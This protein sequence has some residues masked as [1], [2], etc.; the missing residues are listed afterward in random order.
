MIAG[1]WAHIGAPLRPGMAD[2]EG[3]RKVVG[4]PGGTPRRVLILGVTPELWRLGWPVGSE[5]RA[6]DL[7][8]EMIGALW[9]GPSGTAVEGDWRALPFPPESFDCVLCDGGLVLLDYPE[10]Q[11]RLAAAVAGVLRPGGRFTIRLFCKPEGDSVEAIRADLAARLI[12]SVHVLKLRLGMALQATPEEG[13]V[14]ND[15]FER[16]GREF[17]GLEG[18]QAATGWPREEVLT[19]SSYEGTVNRY[20]FLSDV[21]SVRVLESGGHL[22][23]DERLESDYPLGERCPLYAFRKSSAVCRIPEVVVR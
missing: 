11:A 6:V 19:L 5:V 10:G 23:C 18:L 17:G 13:V 14:L 3:F 7:S 4:L 12:P 22:V 15:V 20:H 1:K 8:Q 16:V 9:P 2:L 21:E